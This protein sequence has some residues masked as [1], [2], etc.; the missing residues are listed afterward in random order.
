MSGATLVGPLKLFSVEG[1]SV[2]R[3][4]HVFQLD[5]LL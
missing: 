4:L 2:E 5:W 3:K 1:L